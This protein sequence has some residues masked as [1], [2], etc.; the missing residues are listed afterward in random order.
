[1]LNSIEKES[2][3]MTCNCF[4]QLLWEHRPYIIIEALD[5]LQAI[6]RYGRE[7]GWL[8]EQDILFGEKEIERRQAARI[9]HQFLRLELKEKDE[10]DW[11]AAMQLQD[12]L[13]CRICINHVAQMY[14]KG[15]MSAYTNQDMNDSD[16]LPHEKKLI[17]GMHYIVEEVEA[18]EMFE[19]AFQPQLRSREHGRVQPQAIKQSSNDQITYEKAI[20]VLKQNKECLLVDVRTA[21]E[22]EEWHMEH[23]IN[24]PMVTILSEPMNFEEN[25][26]RIILL[27]CQRGYQSEIAARCLL[28]HGYEH[29]FYFGIGH[30]FL[31]VKHE[32]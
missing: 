16:D 6:Q 26:N 5:S 7:Q 13:D 12:L 22:Y 27:Y 20:V 25:K 29:V 1:M 30:D 21:T 28:D 15:I 18:K 8:E 9:L 32:L 23:A 3:D 11:Q 10:S 2:I 17:F 31:I 24:I 4:V 19:R 14:T